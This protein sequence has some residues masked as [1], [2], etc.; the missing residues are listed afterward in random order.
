MFV[1]NWTLA[2]VYLATVP[3][4]ATLMWYSARRMRPMYDHLEEAFG[5]Y[6]AAQIDAI[7]GIETVK[8][9]AAEP[10]LQTM[11]LRQFRTLADRIY[12]SEFLVMLYQGALQLVTFVSLALFLF[13]GA[14]E[15]VHGRMTL[16][17]F[18]AFNA[19]IAV[20]NGPVLLLL[21][22]WDK[23]QLARV[24]LGRL[25]DVLQHEPEQGRDRASLREVTKL[26]GRVELRGVR[27]RYGGPESPLVLDDINLD[28]R[29]SESVAIVGRSGSGKTT[30][31]KLLA[32]LLE[33]TDGTIYYDGV[34]LHALD[35]RT[36]RRHVGFVLQESYLFNTTI[37]GNIGFGDAEPDVER[38]VWASRA[39]NAHEFV[40]RLPLGYD[41]HVGDAG[42][43]LSGGQQQRIVIA[44][45]L[46][47]RPPILL[48]D[49]ATGQLDIESERVVKE[50]LEQLLVDRNSFVISHRLN[51]IR[52]VDRIV[53]L[54]R[55]RIAE[56]G[57]HD[58]LMERQGLYFYLASQQL[59][60]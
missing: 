36:L 22:L 59:E 5:H 34:E 39:A 52:N 42:L 48:L 37:A 27:F 35:Y 47:N 38:V 41:T 33:P 9:T 10:A 15:V 20:A 16:G 4:Y 44:R 1:L 25:D 14:L 29:P 58:E 31:I 11:M 12:T 2:L 60:L 55:G 40:Q 3:V 54:E 8:A 30:L 56:Q 57:T 43:R 51:T 18:V 26:S 13:V 32:G 50:S 28:V 19:L 21:A 23:L 49:E 24:Q 53:V 7:R 46:Y 45:A 6:Q 17:Q